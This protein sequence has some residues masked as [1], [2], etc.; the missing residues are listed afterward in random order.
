M[1]MA[2][3]F[4]ADAFISY[5][6]LDN[7][8]LVEGR[9][10]WVANLQRALAIRVAQLLG[11]ESRI[12]WDRKL[13]GN[14]EFDDTLVTRLQRVA[15]LVAVVS[16]RYVKSDWGRKEIVEFCK[17]ATE[18]GGLEVQDKCALFKVLKTQ[19]PLGEHPPE[20]QSVLG[21]EFFKIEPETGNARELDEIFGPEASRSSGSSS[22]TSPMTCAG[23]SVCSKSGS[24]NPPRRRLHRANRSMSR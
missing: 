8:E 5:A 23:C 17:A 14:D 1:R 18:Q 10:G 15:L 13:R 16:P 7:V 11:K 4:E 3:Q 2:M 20:L 6:H 12:W 19:V 21:Y 22:T 24:G 9:K